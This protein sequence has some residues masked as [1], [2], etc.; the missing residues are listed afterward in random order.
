MADLSDLQSL[1]GPTIVQGMLGD[2]ALS[3]R[4][5]LH[6]REFVRLLA[7]AIREY[8]L[9]RNAILDQMA[10][11]QRPVRLM[12]K[13][14]RLWHMIGFTDHFETCINATHRCIQNFEQLK[15][16]I[17]ADKTN[18]RALAA[19]AK[20]VRQTRHKLEHMDEI[21]HNGKLRDG[22]PIM[23][24]LAETDD[25]ALIAGEEISFGDLARTLRHLHAAG[26][27]MFPQPAPNEGTGK[28]LGEAFGKVGR[29]RTQTT[30]NPIRWPD[31]VTRVYVKFPC[32]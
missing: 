11:A 8:Q 5:K 19:A 2:P 21:I 4:A 23:I 13:T 1:I 31:E 29:E 18:K 32:K 9:A 27:A 26:V 7:K 6:R 12:I 20:N 14:G 25:K 15:A 28:G 3:S 30:A 22:E 10:E 16:A 24:A 17:S